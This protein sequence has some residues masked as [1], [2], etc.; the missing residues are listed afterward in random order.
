[1]RWL[2]PIVIFLIAFA[3]SGWV[4][5][6]AIPGFIMDKA[7]TRISASGGG[8]GEVRHAPRLT[9]G[10]QTIVRASPDILYSV[11]VYDLSDGDRRITAHWP[12]DSLYAS[13]SLYDANT[14]NFAVI[15]DRDGDAVDLRLTD[16]A[17]ND[18]IVSP[19]ARGLILYRRVIDS[20]TDLAAADAAR[21]SFTCTRVTER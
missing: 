15:S 1:M 9:E 6:N 19:T 21:R 11:C 8:Q 7:M 2:V 3:A 14:N 20:E 18:A 10:N 13:V 5:L 4:T 12:A 17:G 16:E